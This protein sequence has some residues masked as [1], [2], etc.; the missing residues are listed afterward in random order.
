MEFRTY[1]RLNSSSEMVDKVL[2][3]NKLKHVIVRKKHVM[4]FT[5][6]YNIFLILKGVNLQINAL[7]C[8]QVLK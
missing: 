3:N 7:L 8:V 6:R 1:M 2:K 4:G 5:V